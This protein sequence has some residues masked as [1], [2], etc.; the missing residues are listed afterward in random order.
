MKET[1]MNEEVDIEKLIEE[2]DAE[3]GGAWL[4]AGLVIS[5]FDPRDLD[6]LLWSGYM[7][8]WVQILGKLM[9]IIS[10]PR[11]VD[12]WKDIAGYAALVAKH[13]VLVQSADVPAPSG[14]VDLDQTVA[15][16]MKTAPGRGVV[17]LMTTDQPAP[18]VHEGLSF[19]TI[20]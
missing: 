14:Q 6:Q 10:S 2:R 8:N 17:D 20:E 12:H 19:R 18:Q 9:R 4:N 13:I 15:E 16:L 7:H 1:K 11:N 3:Y 5:S